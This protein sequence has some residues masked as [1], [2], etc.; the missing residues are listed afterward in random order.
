PA[1]LRS[2]N[3]NRYSAGKWKNSEAYGFTDFLPIDEEPGGLD[4]YIF[5]S[6]EGAPDPPATLPVFDFRGAVESEAQLPLPGNTAS[7]RGFAL[8]GLRYNSLGTIRIT[9]KNSIIRG[10]V[11]WQNTAQLE[12][13]PMKEDGVIPY[14]ENT[15]VRAIADEL[16]LASLPT[17]EAKMHVISKWFS[18][19]FT[20]TRYLTI[21][22][23][24]T[25]DEPSAISTFLTEN[26]N[27]HCEYFA[28]AASLLLRAA[29][30]PT[31]Y[32][33]G[34][35]V[36]EK[37][38]D[39]Y[40]V[41][42]TH[43]HAWVRAWDAKTS[44]WIDFD[45]TPGNWLSM[46]PSHQ[47]SLQWLSDAYLKI[48]EDFGLWRTDPANRTGLGIGMAIIGALVLAFVGYRLWKSKKVVSSSAREFRDNVGP[49]IR[50]PLHEL[51]PVAGRWLGPRPAGLP[52]SKWLLG[53]KPQ[54]EEPA[55]LD[56]AIALH[57]HLRYDPASSDAS[58]EPLKVLV[59]RI[60]T[61]LKGR[62]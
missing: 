11:A 30:V 46:E 39:G 37:D 29:D 41:R 34:Y 13:P 51:E 48:R 21:S 35:V 43:A 3:F 31:R 57:Q 45:P 28:T 53:L 5:R 27:G 49:A 33:I 50:T 8:D 40:V 32:A 54:L 12:D 58:V 6:T 17:L 59:E 9:P 2:A 14:G 22:R 24:R 25:R 23:Q 56:E 19:E 20:Y 47:S 61:H 55:Q 7:I 4:Y 42:G 26:R 44:T 38:G 36:R 16:K 18:N 52:Y 60:Q 62:T 1:L 10:T 15:T